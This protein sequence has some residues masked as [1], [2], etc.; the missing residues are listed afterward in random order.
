MKMRPSSGAG[1]SDGGNDISLADRV[2]FR[3]VDFRTVAIQSDKP[4]P[5][6]DFDVIPTQLSD[7]DVN[8][9]SVVNRQ[10]IVAFIGRDIPAGMEAFLR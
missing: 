2:S 6:I 8:D 10:D 5:V 1:C 9:D 3:S 4:F 7:P